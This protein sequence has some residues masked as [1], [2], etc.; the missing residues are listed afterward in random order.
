MS[1]DVGITLDEVTTYMLGTYKKIEVSRDATITLDG[2]GDREALDE[3]ADLLRSAVAALRALR[4]PL[5][6]RS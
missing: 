4:A 6:K 3:R 2:A 5:L 1:E